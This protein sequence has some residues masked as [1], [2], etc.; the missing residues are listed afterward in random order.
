LGNKK[1]RKRFVTIVNGSTPLR[2]NKDFMGESG[3][4]IFLAFTIDPQ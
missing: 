4:P 1:L 2:S 3:L